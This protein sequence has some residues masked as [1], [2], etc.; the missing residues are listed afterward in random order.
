MVI[1]IHFNIILTEIFEKFSFFTQSLYQSKSSWDETSVDLLSSLPLKTG[2]V[3]RSY[4]VAQLG[5][6]ISR[7][8]D[9]TATLGDKLNCPTVLK[10]KKKKFLLI[11]SLNLSFN[12][13]LLFL[14][15]PLC[16]AVKILAL[17]P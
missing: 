12:S 7:D 17:S 9:S 14:V 10:E 1:I 15:L 2:F 3:V 8:G 6:K 13:H 11:S 5:L 4:Q 16:A